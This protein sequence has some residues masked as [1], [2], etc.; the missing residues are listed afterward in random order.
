MML[1]TEYQIIVT[2]NYYLQLYIPVYLPAIVIEG[3]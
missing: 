1:N 3:E 2:K